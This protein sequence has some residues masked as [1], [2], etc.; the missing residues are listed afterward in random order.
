MARGATRS[1]VGALPAARRWMT[2]ALVAALA[3]L[4]LSAVHH[5]VLSLRG[6]DEA[7]AWLD[8]RRHTV[9][10]AAHHLSGR[11]T[12]AMAYARWVEGVAMTPSWWMPTSP[13]PGIAP[14]SPDTHLVLP[15]EPSRRRLVAPACHIGGVSGVAG[16]AAFTDLGW[17]AGRCGA[18]L[19]R[20]TPRRRRYRY[21]PPPMAARE[22]PPTGSLPAG[23]AS[24]VARAAAWE[25]SGPRWPSG[26][27]WR[28]GGR[29]ARRGR[30]G[31]RHR[32][33]A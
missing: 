33:R 12:F 27:A 26:L 23:A 28:R 22:P 19:A 6:D 16:D 4:G 1:A 21:A 32:R 17:P 11:H 3:L 5:A 2:V 30:G 25:C 18:S 9:S 15:A 20:M 14:N 29:R 7:V 24:G 10:D 8:G 13:I 31:A